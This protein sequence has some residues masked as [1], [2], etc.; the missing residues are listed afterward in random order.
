MLT[1]RLTKD[2]TVPAAAVVLVSCLLLGRSALMKVFTNVAV[3]V[4]ATAI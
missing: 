4:A 1:E 3:A 2:H